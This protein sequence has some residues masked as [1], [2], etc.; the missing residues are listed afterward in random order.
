MQRRGIGRLLLAHL[1]DAA[2][3]R[4]I[5]RVRAEVMGANHAVR[6][7]VHELDP[8]VTPVSMDGN[9]A[10]YDLEVPGRRPAPRSRP[11]S[12]LSDA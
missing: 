1:A 2:R 6:A 9:I 11:E 4:G 5:R 10:V 7:L 8:N 12:S 3:E